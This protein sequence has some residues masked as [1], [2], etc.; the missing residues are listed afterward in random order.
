M[1]SDTLLSQN[2]YPWISKVLST[3]SRSRK[4]ISTEAQGYGVSKRES[5]DSSRFYSRK[6]YRQSTTNN[7]ATNGDG[8]YE[9]NNIEPQNLNKLFCKSSEKMD[10]LPEYSVHLMGTAR[11]DNGGKEDGQDWGGKEY[12]SGRE[13]VCKERGR[14]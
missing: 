2:S 10:E 9:E 8:K 1:W 7:G 11:P 5:H 6:L 3:V 12:R 14:G 4:R 13:E